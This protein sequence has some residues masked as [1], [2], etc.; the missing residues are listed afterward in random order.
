[1]AHRG[2]WAGAFAA[3]LIAAHFIA[4]L[5]GAHAPVTLEAQATVAADPAFWLKAFGTHQTMTAGS[6]YRALAW[7]SI[8][9]AND[10]GRMTS[11][12]VG[13]KNGSRVIYV[14]AA[15]GGVWKSEDRGDTWRPV[16]E[17]EAT[18]S[19]G[20]VAVAPSN[21]D[22]VWVGT[23]EDNLFRAGL[24]GTGIYKSTDAGKTW[25]HMGLTDSGTIGRILVH[26]T[27][28]DIVYVAASGH[29]WTDNE[30]RGVFM[31]TDGGKTWTKAFYRSPTTGAVDLVM[32]PSDPNTLYAGMWQ[33]A[34]RKWSDPRVEPGYSEGGI[35]KTTDGGKTWKA[36]ND[37]LTPAQFRGRVGI[38]V[39]RSN[40][41]TVYAVI[42]SYEQGRPVKPGERDAY[43]RPLP[44]GS[45]IIK[46]LV[47]FR[48]D[49]KGGS[50]KQVSG[51]TPETAVAMMGL[52]GTYN[53]V[54]TQIRVD[55]MDVNT[56]YVQ[57]L[58]T[59]VSHDGGA[60]FAR[61]AASGGDNH[62]MWIDPD[63]P[64]TTYIAHDGGFT[65][66]D[67]GGQTRKS[68]RGINGT[69]FYNVEVDNAT[70]FHIYGSVQDT[71][72][73][74]VALDVSHG[75]SAIAPL[76]W[77]GA[78]GGEG[79]NQAIDPANPNIVYSH[80]YYGNFS[81]ADYGQPV[82]PSP[83]A[84]AGGSGAGGGA[85][86]PGAP[87]GGRGRDFTST[88]IR[89][90]DQDLRAQWMAPIIVSQF[91]HQTIYAG[92]Q[93]LLRSHDRGGTW[94][95]ISAVLTSNDPKQMGINPSAIPYQT[96][97]Q[98]AESPKRQGLLYVGT[99]DGH[100]WLTR[101]DGKTWTELT[102]SI[103]MGTRKWVSRIVPSRTDEGTVYVAERGREDDDFAP[104]L[105]KSTDDGKTWKSLVGN[106]PAGSINV[107]REDP[108]V[109]NLLYVGN[110]FGV[111]VSTDG[112]A[113]WN[114]LGGNLPTNEVSDIQIQARDNVI[115][116]AT[117]GRGMFVMDATKVRAIK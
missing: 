113:K 8:G 107:I 100:L 45:N 64:L 9:P 102:A 69:Q 1:M 96:I 61:Y 104:Y 36:V 25:T 13:D 75:W 34:R 5:L 33:R 42:D 63:H 71:G 65:M 32:D 89:P 59:N 20:D 11:I 90:P 110:D 44:E 16:F 37:G 84:R 40:P 2:R 41:S 56:V 24:A 57:A 35:W 27:N 66:T 85:A 114:V 12:A 112:G 106:I 6:P 91:D 94:E 49:D 29:E 52:G 103:P 117:Y 81:R 53:W 80:G 116:A 70:P 3:A 92:Y 99:D 79:S 88:N 82:A 67:D 46:G 111:Y 87:G 43:G 74:R 22:I 72:S 47:V 62:R 10:T 50:W 86:R 23:G 105:W 93:Y 17:H 97:T 83:A 26:P 31:S 73:H 19:V 76:N 15:S 78:P 4:P 68:A 115:V 109:P 60:T 14:G 48:S 7:Q 77:D 21:P 38:D 30:M 54:F 18:A 28:P 55:P 58:N 39:S 108:A 101:D 95:K 51:L 98:I